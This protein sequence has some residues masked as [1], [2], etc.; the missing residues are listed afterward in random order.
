MNKKSAPQIGAAQ[1][2]WSIENGDQRFVG[3]V[4]DHT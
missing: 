4:T 1:L 2:L 3:A